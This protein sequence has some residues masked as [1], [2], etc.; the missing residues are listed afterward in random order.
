MLVMRVGRG[1]CELRRVVYSGGAIGVYTVT[2]R[3]WTLWL[4]RGGCGVGED[5]MMSS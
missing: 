3:L 1:M 5:G 4:A 2:R